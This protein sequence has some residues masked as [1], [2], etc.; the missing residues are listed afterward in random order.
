M[1][2]FKVPIPDFLII[3]N[4]LTRH[5]S[6]D[7]LDTIYA[8]QQRQE[9]YRN[10][11]KSMREK[12]LPFVGSVHLK[13]GI[14]ETATKI[15]NNIGFDLEKRK[16]LK[17]W[18]EAFHHFIKQL[19]NVWIL[20]MC[21]SVVLNNNNRT[22]NPEEFRGFAIADDLASLIFINGRDTKAAQMF[23]LAHELAHI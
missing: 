5:P 16:Q 12:S 9:W 4:E 21:S 8:C 13:N 1:R 15:R 22:L 23:T 18:D 7:L 14:E 11:M 10:F 3:D 17:T 20:V 19:D 2:A 6:P